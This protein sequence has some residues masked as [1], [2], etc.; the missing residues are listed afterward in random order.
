M[1]YSIM[2]LALLFTVATIPGDYSPTALYIPPKEVS[3]QEPTPPPSPL[4]LEIISVPENPSPGDLVVLSCNAPSTTPLTWVLGNSDKTF[5]PVEGGTKCVFASGSPGKYKFY[6]IAYHNGQ[7]IK[8]YKYITVGNPPDPEPDPDN[9]DP[10]EP[11]PPDPD[12]PDDDFDNIGQRVST[13]SKGL[14]KKEVVAKNF[15]TY[16]SKLDQGEYIS[17]NDAS[18]AMVKA[19]TKDLGS[20][21]SKWGEF[22][23][24]L[25]SDFTERWPMSKGVV[26]DYWKAISVGLGG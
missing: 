25:N 19:R 18:Q 17:I 22:N 11:T 26:V 14:P 3:A 7:L 24:R 9:P 20:D 8:S 10:P 23:Q 21:A 5:L 4:L 15:K 13:W 2:L 1:K 6:V 16:A 12:I